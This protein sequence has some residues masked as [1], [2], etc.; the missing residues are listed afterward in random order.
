MLC[1]EGDIK[2][3]ITGIDIGNV[4]MTSTKDI[5]LSCYDGKIIALVDSRKFK[6]QGIM[7]NESA[8]VPKPAAQNAAPIEEE[9]PVNMEKEKKEVNTQMAEEVAKLEKEYLELLSQVEGL[10]A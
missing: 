1:F 2:S 3:T 7:A 9:V 6:K 10:E 5:L 4:T 8:P